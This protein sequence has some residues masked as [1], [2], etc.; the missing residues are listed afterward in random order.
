LRLCHIYALT[1]EG[2]PL[3][4][5]NIRY[6]GKTVQGLGSRLS[7][8]IADSRTYRH[9][10]ANWIKSLLKQ[11]L[12]PQIHLIDTVDF[13]ESS[14]NE[15]FWI[16]YFRGLNSNLTNL[17]D[18]GEGTIGWVP[19]EEWRKNLSFIHKGK[20]LS[21]EHKRKISEAESGNKNCNYGKPMSEEQK[22]KISK[23]LTGRKLPIETRV[24]LSTALI[25]NQRTLGYKHSDKTKQR[26][27]EARK[28]YLS[29]ITLRSN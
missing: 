8:H 20:R 1:E 14:E 25:G 11:G 15:I 19:S 22:S 21:D 9:H 17:T 16:A 10:C 29:T 26:M 13:N 6:I 5:E 12:S 24:K 18:G 27:R 3:I 23:T 2:K 7:N 4:P 28:K